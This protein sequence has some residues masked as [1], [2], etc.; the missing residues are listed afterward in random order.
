[1]EFFCFIPKLNNEDIY[2]K[3]SFKIY[4]FPNFP[5]CDFIRFL[6]RLGQ[7]PRIKNLS[8]N[9]QIFVQLSI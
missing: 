1:M 8:K 9:L 6:E 5:S 2:F 7:A 4:L 3:R